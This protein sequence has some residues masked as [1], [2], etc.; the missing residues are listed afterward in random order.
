M[1]VDEILD[2]QEDC[3]MNWSNPYF[4]IANSFDEE[5]LRDM[6]DYELENMIKVA[7]AVMEG[8]A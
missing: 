5:E 8:L 6:S 4:Y 3:L 7:E 2:C 1:L